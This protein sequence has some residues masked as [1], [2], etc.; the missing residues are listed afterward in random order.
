MLSGCFLLGFAAVLPEPL[1]LEDAVILHHLFE[2]HRA[3]AVDIHTGVQNPF[4]NGDEG[5]II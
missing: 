1:L 3:E 4:P 2:G 5:E